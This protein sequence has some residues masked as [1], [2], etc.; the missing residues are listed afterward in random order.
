MPASLSP[1]QAGP[2]ACDRMA[3]VL[4]AC[5]AVLVGATVQA[6]A[7]F[8]LAL[9]AG[10]A[11]VAVLAPTEAVATLSVLAPTTT[12]LLLLVRRGWRPALP[13]AHVRAGGPAAL[14]R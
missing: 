11:L 7:G 9:I 10:P 4:L 5:L 14:D 13:G 12:P 6:A 8:G 1:E 3:G 2:G